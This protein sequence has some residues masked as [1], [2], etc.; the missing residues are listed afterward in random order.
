MVERQEHL[1]WA[2][3]NQPKRLETK[4]C[5]VRATPADGVNFTPYIKLLRME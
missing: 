5:I 3:S 1:P 4:D 2:S